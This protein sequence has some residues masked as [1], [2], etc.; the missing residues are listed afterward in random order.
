MFQKNALLILAVFFLMT[1]CTTSTITSVSKDGG[2]VYALPTEVVDRMLMDA[3]SAE[4]SKGEISRGSASYPS[5]F[6]TVKWG[7]V[8]SDTITASAKPAKGRRVDGEIISG[9]VFEVQRH[10]SAP[11]TGSPTAK[12]IHAKLQADAELTGTGA[13]FIEFS[14]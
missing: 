5:Y 12:R 11:A 9:Y 7:A 4:I 3:M 10:G 1:G 2:N 8:D 13:T 14:Q 6:G